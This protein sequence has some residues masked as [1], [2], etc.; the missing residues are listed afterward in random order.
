MTVALRDGRRVDLEL[1]VLAT[2]PWCLRVRWRLWRLGVQG[3]R[4]RDVGRDPA[5]AE[6]LVRRGGQDQVPCLFVDGAPMYES[7]TI[8]AWL[9]ANVER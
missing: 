7:G 3:V 1:F 4:L 8:V 2:C 5:A 6:E 9:A